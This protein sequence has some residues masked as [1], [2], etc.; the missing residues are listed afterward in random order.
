MAIILY[1]AGVPMLAFALGMYLPFGLNMAVLFGA[2]TAW[3]IS[4]TGGSERVRAAR[5]EQGTLI[6]SGLMA[7]A[8]LFGI[9]TAVLRIPSI[10]GHPFGWIRY[11]SV[12]I[13]FEV[14]PTSSGAYMLKETGTAGYYETNGQI[15]SLIMLCGLALACFLL[16]R[17]GAK[18]TIREEDQAGK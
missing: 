3:I 12:G 14:A 5:A 13:S 1:M 7:G 18:R 16:A 11:I 6:A 15:I 4:K 17:W 9:L 8:A 10:A 2:F